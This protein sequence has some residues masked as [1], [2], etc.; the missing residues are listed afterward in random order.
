MI[1]VYGWVTVRKRESCWLHMVLYQM[2]L[3][4]AS[5]GKVSSKLPRKSV[6]GQRG[7]TPVK[8]LDG[9]MTLSGRSWVRKDA[10]GRL[11]Y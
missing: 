2:I 11:G 3:K 6:V 7:G 10:C 1:L 4:K 8:K 9:G 5:F